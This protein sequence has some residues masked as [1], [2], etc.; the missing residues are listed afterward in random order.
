VSDPGLTPPVRHPRAVF[1]IAIRFFEK[2]RGAFFP[3]KSL[4]DCVMKNADRFFR[5]GF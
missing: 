3:E 4:T 5:K 2:N 1:S